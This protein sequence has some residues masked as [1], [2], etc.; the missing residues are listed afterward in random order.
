MSMKECRECSTAISEHAKTCPKCGVKKP[1]EAPLIRGINS[2]ASAM[3]YI[4]VIALLLSFI[5]VAC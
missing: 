2:V 5:M 1:F 4:G 3:F